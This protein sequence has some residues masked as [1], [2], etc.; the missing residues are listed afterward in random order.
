MALDERSRA[1]WERT[2]GRDTK[3]TMDHIAEVQPFLLGLMD[4]AREL[5]DAFRCQP[6]RYA[7]LAPFNRP[8]YRLEISRS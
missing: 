4:E 7:I 8:G 6:S 3:E 5:L 1:G 2:L